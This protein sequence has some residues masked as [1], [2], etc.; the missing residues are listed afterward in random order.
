MTRARPLLALLGLPTLTLLLLVFL[1]PFV[2][3]VP[4]PAAAADDQSSALSVQITSLSPA[5]IP[6]HGPIVIHGVIRNDT[7]ETWTRLNVYPLTAYNPM[8]T[9]SAVEAAALTDPDTTDFGQ[10]LVD[11]GRPV[12]DLV[13]G[14]S[15][16]FHLRVPRKQ[17]QISGAP[18]VYWLGAHVLGEN[19]E[20][21]D[22]VAD[23]RARTFIPLLPR[24][25]RAKV[26]LVIPVR[27]SV[28]RTADGKLC[29]VRELANA[30]S[31]SGRLGRIAAFGENAA[32]IPLTWLV[33]PAV[34]DAAQDIADGDPPLDIRAAKPGQA[35]P[36]PSPSDA[37][38]TAGNGDTTAPTLTDQ[39][40]E[41][42][43]AWLRTMTELLRTGQTLALPYAD[44]DVSAIARRHAD[45]LDHAR[46][47]STE[48]FKAREINAVPAVAPVDGY[49]DPDVVGSL[50]DTITAV[51]S[52]HGSVPRNGTT[53]LSAGRRF[54]LADARTSS[55]GPL[56][57]PQ[58]H[59][60][61][62][63][64]RIVADAAVQA[65]QHSRRTLVV[66]LPDDWSPD[67]P[68]R[69]A[70][71]YSGLD[72]AW[73]QLT[74]LAPGRSVPRPTLAW[75]RAAKR[76][77]IPAW[78]ARAARRLVHTG[79]VVQHL[80][81]T[82]NALAPRLTGAA[83]AA[84]SYHA[85][86][87]PVIARTR[88]AELDSAIRI[89]LSGV[90]VIGTPFV[91]LSGESGKLTISVLNGLDLPVKVSL[92]ARTGNPDITIDQPDPVQVAAGQRVTVRLLAHAGAIGVHEVTLTPV[93][94][95]GEKV[96]SPLVFNLRTSQ[97]GMVFWGIMGAGL[98]L[99]VV[100]VLRQVR[101]R[102]RDRRSTT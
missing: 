64:Q 85:R 48:V 65:L 60:L 80:V 47:M 89:L 45:L 78:N 79:D 39:D 101:R 75:P 90:R 27:E 91:T 49:L 38:T 46:T 81:A 7:D 22:N 51:L 23:G 3:W 94:T 5:V 43:R 98:A 96:G 32:G 36:S 69:F 54:V 52:D 15:T 66:S 35:S 100:M 28:R 10:R 44:P 82:D 31:P 11:L 2:P 6:R 41:N 19:P 93:T 76:H 88:A 84:V 53:Q 16:T 73:L 34:L 102:L 59:V 62:L 21:R 4:A 57:H 26:A 77:E 20:G 61:G 14:A 12:G 30:F 24:R 17:L 13:P 55:G 72:P 56:P 92:Q 25:A 70:A 29:Q 33:D 18:G 67:D 63:R 86:P 99:L 40:R 74:T 50:R 71:F 37:D 87:D 42:A 97:V 1:M 95:T 58:L 9:R 83:L 68:S 8:T